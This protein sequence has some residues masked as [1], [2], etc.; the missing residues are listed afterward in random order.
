MVE[1][2]KTLGEAHYSDL[3]RVGGLH[4][5]ITRALESLGSSLKATT[6][7]GFIPFACVGQGS[8][9]IQIYAAAG[10]RLFT[11]EFWFDGVVYG[12]GSTPDIVEAAGSAHAWVLEE[13]KISSMKERFRFF[14]PSARGEAHEAGTLLEHEWGELLKHWEK[15]DE[16]HG[17]TPSPTPLIRAAMLR[18][19]LRR[20]YPYTSLYRLGFRRTSYPATDDCPSAEPL[21]N[22]LYRAYSPKHEVVKRRHRDWEYQVKEFEIIGEGTVEEVIDLLVANLPRDE[23]L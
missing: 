10:R 20:L 19:E 6:V 2:S 22:G 16:R 4:E 1:L 12:H 18:P 15:S 7:N 13:P 8:R 23:G 5:G 11:L 14:R 3:N 17:G 9:F 21:G